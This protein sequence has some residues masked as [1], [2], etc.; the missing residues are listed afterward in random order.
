MGVDIC[1][2][3]EISG[4]D[5]QD[6]AK[7]YAW[8]GCLDLGSLGLS[9]GDVCTILFGESKHTF[10]RPDALDQYQWPPLAKRRGVP[11]NMAGWTAQAVKES[12]GNDATSMSTW[13]YT[14]ISYD[15]IAQ[16]DWQAYPG[17][18]L[19]TDDTLGWGLLFTLMKTLDDASK[20]QRLV[21]WFEWR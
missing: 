9:T 8:L 21:V 16:I 19:P 15:E 11:P 4:F 5:E 6:L 7:D 14:F 1:G 20:H 13:G 2:F 18:D 12:L 17:A 10:S 3:I